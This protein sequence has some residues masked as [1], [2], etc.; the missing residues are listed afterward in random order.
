MSKGKNGGQNASNRNNQKA[1]VHNP[2]SAAHKATTDN[3]SSQKNS[4]NPAY[5]S[6]RQGNKK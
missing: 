5:N 2:G 4:N 3:R 6:S 1:N